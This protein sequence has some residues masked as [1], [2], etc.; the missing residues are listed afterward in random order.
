[1]LSVDDF[2]FIRS[3]FG[4]NIGLYFAY[5]DQYFMWLFFPSLCGVVAYF[6]GFQKSFVAIGAALN[7]TWAILFIEGN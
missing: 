1:V 4:E 7:N 6:A 3:H 5:L 2:Q